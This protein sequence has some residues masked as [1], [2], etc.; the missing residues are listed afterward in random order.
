[1]TKR[2]GPRVATGSGTGYDAT[3]SRQRTAEIAARVAAVAI[4]VACAVFAISARS[5]IFLGGAAWLVVLATCIAGYGHLAERMIVRTEVDLGLRMAWGAGVY[6]AIAGILLALGWLTHA[7]LATLVVL[8]LLGFAWRQ[9]TTPVPVLV[10]GIRALPALRANP[11][12]SVFFAI[13]AVLAAVNVAGGIA[14]VQGNTYDDDIVYTALIKRTL[15]IGDIDEPFSFRRISAYGGQTALAALAPVRGTLANIYLV[16]AALFQ[17]IM[18]FLIIGLARQKQRRDVVDASRD[19][20]ADVLLLGLLLVVVVLLPN[21]SINTG[22]HWTGVVLFLGLYRTVAETSRPDAPLTRL[23]AMTGVLA[24]GACT[25][26]QNYLPVGLLFP[27]AVLLIRL[28]P[29]PWKTFRAER[30]LWLATLVGGAIALLPYCI[31]SYRSNETFL[32]PFWNGTFNPDIQMQPTLFSAGQELHFFLRV[33][34]EPDP[35]RVWLVLL[36]VLFL[37][38]DTRPGRP[39]TALTVASVIG[40]ILLVHS[41]PLSDAR[42][43]WRYGFG[44]VFSLFVILVIDGGAPGMRPRA[45]DAVVRVPLLGRVVLVASL[46][47]QM[48]LSVRGMTNKYAS[49][50]GDID[51]ARMTDRHALRSF[52]V[53]RT[54]GEL[55]LAVPAGATLAILLDEPYHLDYARNHI[56]NIDTPGFASYRPGMPFFRGPEPV[57]EYFLTHGIRYL[58][59][60]RGDHSRYF[61]RRD[62]WLRRTLMDTE[63]WRILGAYLVDCVDNFAALASTRTVLYEHNGMVLLDLG[64][65]TR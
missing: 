10:A 41:F 32:Y 28:G 21:T 57:A 13:I 58:A 25:L 38:R 3:V 43:L 33:L 24:A 34:I 50:A 22:S 35:I 65:G 47:I 6:L 30:H 56:I 29:R 23:F 7:A 37:A 40:F 59:F 36:P 45:D 53:P 44:Y 4:P 19:G 31:A 39:L 11:L 60:V 8:G 17:V 5:S 16:D 61:Y 27:V 14:K 48:A 51:H 54:Y 18:L 62:M 52:E 49:I 9:V 63:L 20:P 64:G 1:V 26:R 42:N 15:D 2:A 46:V 12:V 55:Q